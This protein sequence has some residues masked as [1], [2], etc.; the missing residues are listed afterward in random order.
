MFYYGDPRPVDK[1]QRETEC[2]V[3]RCG[4]KL[5]EFCIRRTMHNISILIFPFAARATEGTPRPEAQKKIGFDTHDLER[6]LKFS[7]VLPFPAQCGY[8]L[9]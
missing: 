4:R 9:L 5:S 1:N 6:L 2:H 8:L 3:I 7:D